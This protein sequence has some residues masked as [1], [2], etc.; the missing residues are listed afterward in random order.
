MIAG[1]S[2]RVRV[3]VTVAV[4]AIIVGCL[5]VGAVRPGALMTEVHRLLEATR[6]SGPVG[7][8]AF[9]AVQV[10]VAASGV[11]PA[12][13]LGLAAGSA[14]GLAFGFPLVAISTMAGALLAF[15]LSRSLFRDVVARRLAS[16]PSLAQFDALL[17]KDSWRIVLL[18][19]I[20]PVM[21][22]AAT[23]YALG[24][25]SVGLFDYTVGTVAAL[26]ALFGYVLIGTLADAGVSAWTGGALP[27]QWALLVLGALATVALTLIVGRLARRAVA[28]ERDTDCPQAPIS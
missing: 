14:F 5:A 3:V 4:A 16:R 25:S 26:P 28:V 17:A 15:A 23:S 13:L 22:F 10:I 24:I 20:S 8:I 21:P 27:L 7:W 9:G 2:G 6:D 11:L 1:S 19:R 12:S 18:L